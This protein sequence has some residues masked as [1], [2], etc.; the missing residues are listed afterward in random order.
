MSAGLARSIPISSSASK[1]RTSQSIAAFSAEVASEI[2][3]SSFVVG[4]TPSALETAQPV[5]DQ[6]AEGHDF[7]VPPSMV[8]AE[9]QQIGGWIADVVTSM[10]GGDE[11]DPAVVAGV[12]AQV[13]ELTHR[14]PIYG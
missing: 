6:L 10:N 9:F 1:P 14:F 3:R 5:L 4:A 2:V 7:E 8:E 13:R 12:A 11:A